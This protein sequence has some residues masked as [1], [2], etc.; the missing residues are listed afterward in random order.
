M[1]VVEYFYV[2]V[3]LYLRLFKYLLWYSGSQNGTR[4]FPWVVFTA[5]TL[6]G[7]DV[8]P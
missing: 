3:L 8:G 7:S 5:H 2:S 1:V 6:A 4:A